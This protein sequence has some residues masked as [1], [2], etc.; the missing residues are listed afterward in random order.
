[1]FFPLFTIAIASNFSL[2]SIVGND[3][4]GEIAQG[5]NLA[6]AVKAEGCKLLIWRC[7]S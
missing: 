7:V 4:K 5:I 2:Q 6:D 3:Q 1:M